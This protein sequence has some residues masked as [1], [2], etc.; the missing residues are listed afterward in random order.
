MLLIDCGSTVFQEMALKSVLLDEYQ[1]LTGFCDL[2]DKPNDKPLSLL[3]GVN[4]L[5]VYIT[6]THGDHVGSLATLLDYFQWRRRKPVTFVVTD[7][8]LKAYL[9]ELL[10]LQ[11]SIEDKKSIA[12][13]NVEDLPVAFP[14]IQ[15]AEA[16]SLK[17][18][19]GMDSHALVLELKQ[20]AG[21]SGGLLFYTGDTSDI[22]T[23]KEFL[24]KNC[25]RIYRVYID[26]TTVASP[27]HINM[28]TLG[29]IVAEVAPDICH[30]IY[31]MHI[32]DG[33]TRDEYEYHA[34]KYG[35][36]VVKPWNIQ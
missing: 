33:I 31:C 23:V 14:D 9:S 10:I 25:S 21:F 16:I 4:S 32:N 8:S 17:H 1:N 11:N 29:T 26:V 2:R 15:R 5:F 20:T 22:K 13:M 12:W 24:A 3:D 28:A 7:E 36:N 18:T 19:V 6:H 30:K 35:F 34:G 27:V